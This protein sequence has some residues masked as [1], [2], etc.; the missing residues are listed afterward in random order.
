MVLLRH[1]EARKKRACN[2]RTLGM[3]D[4]L[5][6]SWAVHPSSR[7]RRLRQRANGC[8][9]VVAGAEADCPQEDVLSQE[10]L[11]HLRLRRVR[12]AEVLLGGL[13]HLRDFRRKRL[14]QRTGNE[15]IRCD[16][17]C[18]HQTEQYRL[19]RIAGHGICHLGD[20]H[21]SH[22]F[23]RLSHHRTSL[24]YAEGLTRF[25]ASWM[26][27]IRPDSLCGNTSTTAP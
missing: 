25:K 2:L 5:G 17:S 18:S 19:P 15:G 10:R 3:A 23:R 9:D 13:L 24:A 4:N 26:V 14:L 6:H 12:Q 27:T 21:I 11:S 7:S 1:S 16:A 8:L 20:K 22:E